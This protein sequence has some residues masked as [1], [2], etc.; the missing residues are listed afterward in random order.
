MKDVTDNP[1]DPSGPSPDPENPSDRDP[2]LDDE[3]GKE[4]VP[5]A[6]I[7][8]DNDENNTAEDNT[9]E[10]STP[11]A[12]RTA[13]RDPF[14]DD[15][16]GK[17]AV[18]FA[19]IDDDSADAGAA[20]ESFVS[21]SHAPPKAP[22][23]DPRRDEI[24]RRAASRFRD[25][26]RRE[27][28][29]LRAAAADQL[30]ETDPD[31]E[32]AVEAIFHERERDLADR[33]RTLPVWLLSIGLHVLLMVFLGMHV[34]G[35]KHTDRIELIA[36]PSDEVGVDMD[37]LDA[38]DIDIADF[39]IETFEEPTVETPIASAVDIQPMEDVP[40][41]DDLV[42]DTEQAAELVEPVSAASSLTGLAGRLEGKARLLKS[43]GGTDA[44]EKAVQNALAWLARH[45]RP[46]GSWSIQHD[47]GLT[48]QCGGGGSRTKSPMAATAL[49]LLPFLGA[50]NTPTRG[51]YA[52]SVARGIDF[53]LANGRRTP[54]G[55][56][57]SDEGGT[58]YSH[59]L[60]TIALC[61][62]CAMARDDE[63][64]KYS[65]LFQAA[66]EAVAFTVFAQDP[67][68]GGWRY[69]PQQPGDTSVVGWQLMALKS[70]E[71]G[72]IHVPPEVMAK[73]RGFLANKVAYDGGTRYGYTEAGPGT[74]ATTAIGL[75]CR[76][77]L[78][79]G[80]D[81]RVLAK[82]TDAII[83]E[84]PKY[85]NPY[86]IYYATQLFHHIGGPKW[87][88]W[89]NQV[90]DELVRRQV[91][92]G[93]RAGSW[94]VPASTSISDSDLGYSSSGGRLFVTSLYCMTLE[95]YYRHMPIYQLRKTGQGADLF[96]I[97]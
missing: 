39:S 43:G 54:E 70:A 71:Y 7:D 69:H 50:G 63:K 86:F 37:V 52:D 44:S 27:Q 36:Q 22:G 68:G 1:F 31:E 24:N 72:G 80:V 87:T 17:E 73:A 16:F 32:M 48:C 64:K 74:D 11:A 92:E 82:G 45:Q 61:E 14:L 12:D 40:L 41:S 21:A 57:L 77:F 35:T 67:N 94:D 23:A 53:L 26:V 95:V 62:A 79:W 19:D 9:A 28:E 18:P 34:F 65:T 8:D 5:F 59:G 3:F 49:A 58:M 93:E 81:N 66:K 4:A 2:F 75:L 91:T 38:D 55:F 83:A 29:E 84:V 96:P 51:K 97:D 6:D 25:K 33:L 20:A 13:G 42:F 56:D 60:A 47:E 78:D 88:T 15:E 46:D 76:L 89:N 10:D 85:S 90:R 30:A